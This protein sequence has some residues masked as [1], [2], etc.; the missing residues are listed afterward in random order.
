LSHLNLNKMKNLFFITLI[1]CLASCKK[2]SV[3]P[4]K[5]D[6]VQYPVTEIVG[7]TWRGLSEIDDLGTHYYQF[8]HFKSDTTVGIYIAAYDES[9][10]FVPEIVYHCKISIAQNHSDSVT[11]MFPEAAPY[12]YHTTNDTTKI[13][14]GYTDYSKIR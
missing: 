4:P 14:D 12:V 3:E 1:I 10:I 7:H 9:V 11:I 2:E 8:M 6:V 5:V 13:T